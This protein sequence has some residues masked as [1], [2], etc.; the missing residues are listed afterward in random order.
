MNADELQR[1][2]TANPFPT[3]DKGPV[4]LTAIM[5]Y[6]GDVSSKLNDRVPAGSY[7]LKADGNTEYLFFCFPG[8]CFPEVGPPE[9][10]PVG[11]LAEYIECFDPILREDRLIGG[12]VIGIT[13]LAQSVK[14]GVGR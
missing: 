12:E 9:D 10:V 3:L 2:Q 7:K 4:T 13:W 8:T 6:R 1:L 14:G 5:T 11:I